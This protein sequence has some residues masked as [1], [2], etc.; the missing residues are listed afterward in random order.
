MGGDDRKILPANM[1]KEGDTLPAAHLSTGQLQGRDLSTYLSRINILQQ[2]AFK[3]RICSNQ[4]PVPR[5]LE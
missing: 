1:A 5:T 3:I 2:N 4:N